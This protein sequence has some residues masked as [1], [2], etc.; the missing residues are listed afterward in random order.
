MRSLP[1]VR[2]AWP[3][4]NGT[5]TF[6]LRDESGR[7]RAGLVDS[8]GEVHLSG[9]AVDSKLPDLSPEL[10]GEL[11][12]HRLN[13]R[14]VLLGADRA[15][16]LVRRDRAQAAAEASRK[17]GQLCSASGLSAAEVLSHTSTRIDFS[18]LPGRTLHDLGEAGLGG[19]QRLVETWPVLVSQ[20]ADLPEHTWQSET[21]VLWRWFDWAAEFGALPDLDRMRALTTRVC[22]MLA[23]TV[24]R[25]VVVHRD[26]H[27]KQLLW[28]GE[29]LGLLDL[30]TA[31]LGEPELDL[32]N[33][34]IHVELRLMQG[35]FDTAVADRVLGLLD[36]LK[37]RLG[38]R[39]ER[40]SAYR[41]S[42]RLRLAYVYA[43]RPSA[44]TWL[45]AWVESC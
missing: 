11:V 20:Q 17:F 31:A 19:W 41:H 10:P 18:L 35:V 9:Y 23:G 42:T 3:G 43:F 26:L 16:K 25:S 38:V 39:E 27:D 45:P 13:R 7:L 15:V 4:K 40:F 14:A 37:G 34:W 29:R 36:D 8:A 24:R 2:R 21:A 32:A 6:E 44:A 30:D 5:L 1:G 28:D 22:Q 12:V 33:L